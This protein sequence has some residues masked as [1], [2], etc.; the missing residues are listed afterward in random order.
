MMSLGFSKP[1]VCGMAL[2]ETRSSLGSFYTSFEK[3]CGSYK[4]KFVELVD[5]KNKTKGQLFASKRWMMSLE[6]SSPFQII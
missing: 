2:N 3:S 4:P 5:A 1:Y 6:V